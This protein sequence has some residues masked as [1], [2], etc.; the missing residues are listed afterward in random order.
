MKPST[1]FKWLIALLV[2]A[3][4]A[5]SLLAQT[6]A[7]IFDQNVP[8]TWLGVD[9]SQTKFIGE[10][11]KG[12]TGNK[13]PVNNDEFRDSFT[14]QWNE[15]FIDEPKKYDI[16]NAINRPS[17]KYAINVALNANKQ[18][19]NKD[20]FSNNPSDFKLINEATIA[21]V[22]K[23]Y[24]FQNNDGIGLIFFVEG[25]SKGA[26]SM[27]IWVTFVDMKSKTVLLTTY[28]TGKP[29]GFGFRNYWA[30]PFFTVLKDME[31]N[32]KSWK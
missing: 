19:T 17:V 14:V 31:K 28:Q 9:F 7:D 15:L 3:A 8:V 22:V 10:P 16:A 1:K 26:G 4:S 23:N 25:M 12:I 18:L 11:A 13:G 27:G 30:K 32:F 24:D 6:R 2:I 29:G 20:F 21:D 5:P